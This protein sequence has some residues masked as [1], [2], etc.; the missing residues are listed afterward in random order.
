LVNYFKLLIQI[1]CTNKDEVFLYLKA[2]L[3]CITLKWILDPK[4]LTA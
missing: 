1:T 2:E 3:Y 4:K